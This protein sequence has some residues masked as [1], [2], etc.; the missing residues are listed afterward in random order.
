MTPW[1]QLDITAVTGSLKAVPSG[2]SVL[3]TSD[4]QTTMSVSAEADFN[5]V[6]YE[7]VPVS[8]SGTTVTESSEGICTV[9][10]DNETIHEEEFGYSVIFDSGT[11]SEVPSLS[12]V[13][14]GS[15]LEK[16]SDPE[17][18]GY[19]FEGWY[20][21]EEMVI[22]YENGYLRDGGLNYCWEERDHPE[23]FYIKPISSKEIVET[24]CKDG[25]GK[26][27]WAENPNVLEQPEKLAISESTRQK[28]QQTFAIRKRAY[29]LEEDK[30]YQT[31]P[32][33][34]E[35]KA[36]KARPANSNTAIPANV[37][38]R[39]IAAKRGR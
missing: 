16:P 9:I 21:N 32:L 14:Q 15:L 27:Y 10:Y 20:K 26:C 17:R 38:A 25:A 23:T 34:E 24:I 19:F 22:R 3:I 6:T 1:D 2:K 7:N 13:H 35:L 5:S 12:N 4:E 30:T 18:P 36:Q 29:N 28:C 8:S 37:A 39:L 33:R 31:L 11:G